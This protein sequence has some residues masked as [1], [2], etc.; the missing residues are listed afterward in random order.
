MCLITADDDVKYRQI[1]YTDEFSGGRRSQIPSFSCLFFSLKHSS[2]LQIITNTSRITSII[3]CF[4]MPQHVLSSIYSIVIVQPGTPANQI[5]S[6]CENR[7][8]PQITHSP[9]PKRA[10]TAEN[11][12]RSPWRAAVCL[13]LPCILEQSTRKNPQRQVNAR[14]KKENRLFA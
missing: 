13:L 7:L 12:N 1:Q 8:R 2:I 10:Q 6:S 9:L 4:K 11:A 3:T 5:D 14:I